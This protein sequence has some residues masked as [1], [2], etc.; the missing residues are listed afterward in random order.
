MNQYWNNFIYFFKRKY[1]QIL[2]VIDFLPIIWKGF[3]FDYRYA[4]D[5]FQH[6]LKRQADFL[7]SDKSYTSCAKTNAAKIRTAIHLMDKVYNDD[8]SCEYQDKMKEL[9]GSDVLEWEFEDIKDQPDHSLLK[10]KY[11]KWQNADEVDITFNKLFKESQEKQ[12]RA[13]KLLWDFTEHNIQSW[14]D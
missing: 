12:K 14:W 6:Q 1:R 8:Y 13:H 4:I 9:Y 2:R 10:Y 11:E 7:E 5:L 3:D